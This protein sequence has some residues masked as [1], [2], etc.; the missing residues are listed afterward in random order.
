MSCFTMQHSSDPIE[1]GDGSAEVLLLPAQV[2]SAVMG[3][4]QEQ[5]LHSYLFPP[6]YVLSVGC[7]CYSAPL[8]LCCSTAKLLSL[9]KIFTANQYKALHLFCT[10]GKPITLLCSGLYSN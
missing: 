5:S 6:P 1:L 2:G 10:L 3:N 4:G 9:Y 7:L 8:T